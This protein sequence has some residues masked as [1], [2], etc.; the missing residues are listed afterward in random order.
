MMFYETA[1]QAIGDT[2]CGREMLI[3]PLGGGTKADQSTGMESRFMGEVSRMALNLDLAEA[4]EVIEMLYSKYEDR[5]S[6][7]PEGKDFEEC[8]IVNSKYEMKPNEQYMQLYS[9][10][11]GEI[12]EYYKNMF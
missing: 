6:N 5:L 10:I 3:G 8:Y 11:I 12:D 2:V 4:N 7:A 9:K 1:A